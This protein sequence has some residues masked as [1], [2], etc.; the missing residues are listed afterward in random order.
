MEPVPAEVT[1]RRCGRVNRPVANYC[2]QCGL[3][4]SV[5]TVQ[6]MTKVTPLMKQ[7]RLV[8]HQ[9][10]RK[11]IRKLLGEPARIEQ[12]VSPGTNTGATETPLAMTEVWNY[13]YEVVDGSKQVTRGCVVFSV[14]E[15]R[16]LTWS[17]PDWS[18]LG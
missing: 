1:C 13:D 9:M 6:S 17:E 16:L 10:T 4:L 8:G 5:P 3:A 18:I 7:W 11:E 2:G 14:P 15:G 12:Q